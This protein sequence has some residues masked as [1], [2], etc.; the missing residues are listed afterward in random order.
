VLLVYRRGLLETLDELDRAG[1]AFRSVSEHF[2][3]A[4]PVGRMLIQILGRSLSSSGP[5][6]STGIVAGMEHKATRA[7]GAAPTGPSRY[8]SRRHRILL[9]VMVQEL[10]ATSIRYHR[11]AIAE[12]VGPDL[13][14]KHPCA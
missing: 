10:D 6:S 2:D 8:L 7:P 1:E 12:E 5:P 9:R 13:L 4:T 11:Q 3:S 14:R